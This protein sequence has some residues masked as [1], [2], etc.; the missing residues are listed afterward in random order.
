MKKRISCLLL[1]LV[2]A[3]SLVPTLAFAATPHQETGLDLT[4]EGA[5][6]D[7]TIENDG[8][9]WDESTYTLSVKDLSVSNS[10]VLPKKDVTINITG[11]CY[12]GSVT[13][14][15]SAANQNITLNGVDGASLSGSI[16]VAGDL[17][18]NN[19]SISYGSIDNGNVGAGNVMRLN[20]SDVTLY[21]MSWMTNA[22]ISLVNSKLNVVKPTGDEWGQFW[23]EMIAM[24]K[25]SEITSAFNIG[26]Y[27]NRDLSD[28]GDVL[29]YVVS[30]AGGKFKQD[31]GEVGTQRPIYIVDANGEYASSFSLKGSA[32]PA[33]SDIGSE[34]K[35]IT[36]AVGGVSTSDDTVYG[37]TIVWEDPTF[38]YNVDGGVSTRWDPET[39]TYASAGG[40]VNGSF[41]KNSINVKVYNHSNAKI[42]ASCFVG[43]SAS[44]T[45]TSYE[46]SGYDITLDVSNPDGNTATLPAAEAGSDLESVNTTFTLGISGAGMSQ[47]ATDL[48]AGATN[49]AKLGTVVVVIG[50]YMPPADPV[51][52]PQRT[53]YKGTTI[54]C[55]EVSSLS[56]VDS[57]TPTGDETESWD[58]SAD[59]CGGV[60]AYLNGTD[61]ILSGNG[62]GTIIANADS[63]SAFSMQA[64]AGLNN[65]ASALTEIR[66]L[67]ILDT[68]H[69]TNMRRMFRG[70][71]NLPAL[72]LSSMNTSSVVSMEEMFNECWALEKLD[73]SGFDTSNVTSMRRMFDI[74]FIGKSSLVSL[75]V[76]SFD[77]K[78]VVDF[79]EMFYGL[80]SLQSLDVSGF[81]TSKA[82]NLSG[83]F[84]YCKSL[85]ELN[86]SNFD[87]SNVTSM[88]ML[89]GDC[90]S[91][92]TI[93]VS[94]FDTS[95]AGNIGGLF[96]GC[97]NLQTVDVTHFNT[98]KAWTIGSMFDRCKSLTSIDVSNFDTSNVWDM[99]SVFYGCH[100]LTSLDV[101]NFNTSKVRYMRHMLCDTGLNLIDVSNF[102]TSSAVD[103]DSMFSV[104]TNL[105]GIRLGPDFTFVNGYTLPTTQIRGLWTADGKWYDETTGIGYTPEELAAVVRTEPTTYLVL[106]PS[107]DS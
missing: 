41:D 37:T 63:S 91:L 8:F 28:F 18:I 67:N 38:T 76:S 54:G 82:E 66:G 100:S 34:N 15:D 93:D 12:F 29:N 58:A 26:N 4:T 47:Y 32:S 16:E 97:T 73:L 23:A 68:S 107:L 17:T 70:N 92:T 44:A 14:N 9:S 33:V 59:G 1:A 75:D 52:A 45:T 84:M 19:L 65:V 7:K 61:L 103:M 105:V 74:F 56:F 2:M 96:S 101:S 99:Q 80:S 102:D 98:S 77:T 31:D 36:I 39:H 90:S 11:S 10:V 60:M 71:I 43:A 25:A 55:E 78:N 3:L 40:A 87:T 89:F 51:L 88:G 81:N 21:K 50:K 106:N 72:D 83:M 48:I 95:K 85:A 27:G 24:D 79:S 35:D 42:D 57:Y 53:W 6:A 22:G 104:T 13:R 64:N 5:Y 20:N 49:E 30:P 69:V 62:R 94:H 86:V 46:V